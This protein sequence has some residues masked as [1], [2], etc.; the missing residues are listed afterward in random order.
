M[1]VPV[2]KRSEGKLD[3]AI[4]AKALA[5]Y[6]LHITDNDKEFPKGQN[7]DFLSRIRT[8]STDIFSKVWAAN[9]ILVNTVESR[10]K[11][12]QVQR[13]ACIDCNTLL[14]LIEIA[15]SLYHQPIKRLKNWTEMVVSVRNQIR[16]WR[17]SDLKRYE[18][19]K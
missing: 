3:V 11:R 16:A 18:N 1:S 12:A 19:I 13:D 10:D 17:E 2:G 4:K 6:T 9:N 7:G 15:C 5:V 14:P 8:L